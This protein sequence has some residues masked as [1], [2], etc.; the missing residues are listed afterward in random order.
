M[1][2]MYDESIA[3]VEFPSIRPTDYVISRLLSDVLVIQH[4]YYKGYCLVFIE[5]LTLALYLHIQIYSSLECATTWST[6]LGSE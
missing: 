6:F 3:L 2:S 4:I 5:A 1:L